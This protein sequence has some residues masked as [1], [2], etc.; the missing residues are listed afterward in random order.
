MGTLRDPYYLYMYI[1]MYGDPI[2]RYC[3]YIKNICKTK[4][5]AKRINLVAKRT[6]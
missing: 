5:I 1:Y 3:I 6:N 2:Q 4:L